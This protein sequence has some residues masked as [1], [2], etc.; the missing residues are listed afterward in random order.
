MKLILEDGILTLRPESV[1]EQEQLSTVFG[2]P[3]AE[4]DGRGNREFREK[5]FGFAIHLNDDGC[6]V[7]IGIRDAWWNY[8]D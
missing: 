3:D 5:A 6:S 4:Q 2:K 8:D 1:A 7:N